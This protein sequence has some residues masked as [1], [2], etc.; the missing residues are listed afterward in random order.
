MKKP[1]YTQLADTLSA[2]IGAFSDIDAMLDNYMSQ[3]DAT[4]SESKVSKAANR[5]HA[6]AIT[7]C[8]VALAPETFK[9]I[10][11]FEN[12]QFTPSKDGFFND[13]NTYRKTGPRTYARIDSTGGLVAGAYK[14]GTVRAEVMR[15]TPRQM[16]TKESL[17]RAEL[18]IEGN[19]P[20]IYYSNVIAD[21]GLDESFAW[22]APTLA[23]YVDLYLKANQS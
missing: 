23:P 4:K 9:D 12:F 6:K 13:R 14:V 21:Y 7:V 10:A 18:V 19:H 17:A 16:S 20:W 3:C 15:V 8:A 1:T 11:V 22:T 5:V 2:L